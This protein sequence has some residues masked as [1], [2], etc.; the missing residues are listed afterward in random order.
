M[1]CR[2]RWRG[3]RPGSAPRHRFRQH[4]VR[5]VR[6]GQGRRLR[7]REERRNHPD[8]GWRIVGTMAYL[9]AERIAAVRP[10][11]PDD[12]YALGVAGYEALTGRRPFPQEN[13]AELARAT[14]SNR[15]LHCP[16]CGRTWTRRWRRSNWPRHVTRSNGSTAPPPC[17]PRSPHE[18]TAALARPSTRVLVARCSIRR[19]CSSRLP[20]SAEPHH[21]TPVGRRSW[22]SSSPRF[23]PCSTPDR[24]RRRSWPAPAHRDPCRPRR[25]WCRRRQRHSKSTKAAPASARAIAAITARSPRVTATAESGRDYPAN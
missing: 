9:S 19:Q 2:R 6:R 14:P 3:Q 25:R 21:E 11:P 12:L 20:S 7:H 23:C 10:P 16:C 22:R 8:N 13:L 1:R 18:L 4:L 15:G 17:A 24:N 5:R